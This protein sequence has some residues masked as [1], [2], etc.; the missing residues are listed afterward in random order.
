MLWPTPTFC[1]TELQQARLLLLHFSIF[2]HY[3]TFVYKI[4]SFWNNCTV[5]LNV[6]CIGCEKKVIKIQIWQFK[7]CNY[8]TIWM[9]LLV[10]RNKRAFVFLFVYIN[11]KIFL[12]MSLCTTTG[13]VVS[14]TK[15]LIFALQSGLP[16]HWDFLSYEV[17]DC[18][19]TRSQ[20]PGV[21]HRSLLIKGQ[22]HYDSISPRVN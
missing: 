6:Y 4:G 10:W 3:L 14:C 19:G 18:R 22:P 12:C 21:F 13:R 5:A 8:T 20:W 17:W 9:S 11:E 1:P 15:Y 7:G 16:P 2:Q